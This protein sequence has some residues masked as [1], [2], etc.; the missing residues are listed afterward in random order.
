MRRWPVLRRLWTLTP[1]LAE[2]RARQVE[3]WRLVGI[4]VRE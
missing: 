4:E 3:N 2:A 1:A